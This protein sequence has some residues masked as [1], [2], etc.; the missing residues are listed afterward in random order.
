MSTDIPMMES[1][2]D[3][4]KIQ[5]SRPI[6]WTHEFIKTH[7]LDIKQEPKINWFKKVFQKI[8]KCSIERVTGMFPVINL[9]RT[10]NI[11]S[12]LLNDIV[13]GM[14]VGFMQL[15]QGMA[16]ALL[17]GLPAVVGLYMGFFPVVFYC[18]LGTS[19]HLSM[20]AIVVVSL[21]FGALIDQRF[22]DSNNILNGTLHSYGLDN[23]EDLD[24]EDKLFH[25]KIKF[26]MALTV[27]SGITQITMGI[28]Q[29]GIIVRFMSNSIVSAFSTGVAIHVI[30]SQLKYILGITI[31]RH[32]GLLSVPYTLIESASRIK[33]S[34]YPEF[35]LSFTCILIIYLVKSQLNERYKSR[36]RFPIPIDL[37]IVV[38]AT[39]ISYFLQLG[40]KYNFRVVGKIPA[41]LPKPFV[42]DITYAKDYIIEGIVIG[43]V[44]FAQSISVAILM[45]RKQGYSIDANK[46]LIAYGT[47]SVF[48][49]FFN[50]YTSAGAV[51]R[52]SVQI[53]SGGKTQVASL[54]GA[55]FVL[56]II[57][58]AGPLFES[59]P[60]CV[61]SSVILV[62]LRSMLKEVLKLRR[63]WKI[64]KYDCVVW[65]FT[66][67]SVILTTL[68][69]GLVIGIVIGIIT[70][71][72]RTQKVEAV[73]LGVIDNSE[74]FLDKNK[75]KGVSITPGITVIA[76]ASPLYYANVDV[77][78]KEVQKK[79]DFAKA[80]TD[81]KV[82]SNGTSSL[83]EISETFEAGPSNDVPKEMVHQIIIECSGISFVDEMGAEAMLQLYEDYKKNGIICHFSHLNDKVIAVLQQSAAFETLRYVMYLTTYDAL[84]AVSSQYEHITTHL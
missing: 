45:A 25:E 19:R 38:I 3:S 26:A 8:C 41:G 16:Y 60:N 58:V 76:F 6:Y 5:I 61:L 14:T 51:S 78:R 67:I 34:N 35:I 22:P 36:L 64:C 79:F 73:S 28:L 80:K 13:A 56:L 47:A 54:V 68:E 69:L 52:T 2:C 15:P 43:L 75:Y 7:Q 4:N 50:C 49:P 84:T 74:I 53:G 72:I 81:T 9:L 23:N 21:M 32:S 57:I 33:E 29:L 20:G 46:E 82:N 59:L 40:D 62:S 17:S 27:I 11:K 12:Y 10:Y 39:P 55:L 30:S 63:L 31:S 48:S 24:Y 70:I 18:I 71:L 66:F 44:A 1:F 42:P 77:F 37:I 83:N 65:I